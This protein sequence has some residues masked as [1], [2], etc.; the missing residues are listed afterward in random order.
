MDHI[1]PTKIGS[2]A[3]VAGGLFQPTPLSLKLNRERGVGRIYEKLYNSFL[4]IKLSHLII[5]YFQALPQGSYLNFPFAIHP[6]F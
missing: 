3:S 2:S 1:L 4:L 6:I 5:K